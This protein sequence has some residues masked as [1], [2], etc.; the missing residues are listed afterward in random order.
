MLPDPII[1]LFGGKLEIYMYGVMIAIGILVALGLLFYYGK[2]KKIQDSFID[3]IFYAAIA[4]IAV[5]FGAAAV[6]QATYNYIENPEAGF[7]LKGGITFLGG[8][9]GGAL[10][11]IAIYFIFRK[12][13]KARLTDVIS[14]IPCC[15]LI[16]HAFGRIGCF[17]AGCCYGKPTNSFLGVQFPKLDHTVYPTQLYEAA[18][19]FALFA[20]CFYL[21]WKKDFKHNLS[22]YFIGYGVFRFFIEFLRDDS[23]GDFIIPFL[24]PSQ[25]WAICMIGVGIGCYFLLKRAF[26]KREEEL[27]AEKAEKRNALAAEIAE[28]VGESVAETQAE[29]E[30]EN[31]EAEQ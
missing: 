28:K 24:T 1:S 30:G 3:F 21:V 31:R 13:Y 22:V 7:D 19:L 26:R 8:F 20:V 5:G 15:I 9:V 2:K 23:R 18:F 16:G 14:F 12:K 17:F 4:A 25:F 6:F 11:F 10:C 29:N 27:A